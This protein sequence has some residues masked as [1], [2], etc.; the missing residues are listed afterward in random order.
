MTK[1]HIAYVSQKPWIINATVKKNVVFGYPYDKKR[2]QRAI[3][4]SNLENDLEILIKRDQTEIGEKGINLSGGQKARLSLARAIYSDA[5]IMIFDD[6]LSAVDIH[7]GKFIFDQCFRKLLKNKTRILVTNNLL[8]L[9]QADHVI[10][11]DKGR[12][13]ANGNY[14]EVKKNEKFQALL[15]QSLSTLKLS[16]LC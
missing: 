1:T 7:V 9:P 14:D 8:L 2:Y 5:D 12:I 3:K 15:K 10:F 11:F 6:P 13:I 4:Y 16:K